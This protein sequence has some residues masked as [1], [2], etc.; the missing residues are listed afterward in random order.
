MR[1]NH[2]PG[3]PANHQSTKRARALD[4]EL[5]E[6]ER[7]GF[8]TRHLDG[9]VSLTAKAWADLERRFPRNGRFGGRS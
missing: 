5:A 7:R 9:S 1:T 6:L 8:L 4:R 2:R 3:L